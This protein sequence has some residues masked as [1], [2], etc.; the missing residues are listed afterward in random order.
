MKDEYLS[1]FA[2]ISFNIPIHP[3]LYAISSS[4]NRVYNLYGCFPFYVRDPATL[5]NFFRFPIAIDI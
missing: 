3:V 5:T 2:S 4:L 1:F